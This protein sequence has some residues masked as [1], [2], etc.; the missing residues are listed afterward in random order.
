M[1]VSTQR[2]LGYL[3]DNETAVDLLNNEAIATTVLR[4]IR[5]KS[6]HPVTIGVHGDWGAGKSS[7]LEMVE[8]GFA[9]DERTVCLKFNGWQFQGFEDAKIALIEG[10]VN[11][12][13]E[14]RTLFAK[15]ADVVTRIRENIDVLKA[16]KLGGKLALSLYTGL[17]AFGLGEAFDA[18]KERIA[19][20]VTDPEQRKAAIDAANELRKEGEKGGKRSV[21]REIAEFRKLFEELIERADVDRIVVLVDDLDRCLP[22]TAIETLE[23]IR[24]FVLMD[25]TAFVVGADE[26]M[27]EYAVGRHFPNLPRMEDAQGYARAYLEKLLQVPFRIPSLGETETRIYVTLLLVGA[28]LEDG[29]P[30]FAGMLALGRKALRTPWDG[31]VMKAD[32]IA[33]V[34]GTDPDQSVREALLTAERVSAVLAAG[35]RGNPRQIKR[36]LNALNLRLAVAEAR[37]FETIEPTRLAK[38][39]L[40]ELF[41]PEAVFSRMASL[42]ARSPDGV[43]AEIAAIEALAEEGGAPPV[44]RDEPGAPDARPETGAAEDREMVLADWRTRPEVLDWARVKPSIGG[45]NLKPY[46]FVIKDRRNYLA[47]AVPLSAK[48]KRLVARLTAGDLNVAA[49]LGELRDL[50]ATEADALFKELRALVLATMSFDRRPPA[51]AGLAALAQAQEGFQGRYVD[52]L[53]ELPTDRLGLGV[54]AGHGFVRDPA[55]ARRL[56]TVL[57]GWA[58][59]DNAV[60]RRGVE[61]SRKPQ[62]RER[63]RG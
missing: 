13:V 49:V 17:P 60:L 19:G 53:S 37:G 31:D 18:V 2:P 6:T 25:K 12:L 35:T 3:S 16:A 54:I 43:C 21:P 28:V 30:R 8:A 44:S 34:L 39:M 59:S 20:L 46:L 10:V 63:R 1:P 50:P 52:V 24:L 9:D 47:G 62:R 36:F 11:G 45:E 23:A 22:D 61:Q 58:S 56:G 14:K 38:V 55:A 41:L 42:V 15:A 4:L 26:R 32:E 48:L 33:G 27:I 29:D 5:R 7:V 40:A 51:L 57:D